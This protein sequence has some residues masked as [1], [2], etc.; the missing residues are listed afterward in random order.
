M[1][2]IGTILITDLVSSMNRDRV[3]FADRILFRARRNNRDCFFH[4]RSIQGK[5]AP[6]C[7]SLLRSSVSDYKKFLSDMEVKRAYIVLGLAEE[8]HSIPKMW[9]ETTI[10]HIIDEL[11]FLGVDPCLVSCRKK[12]NTRPEFTKINSV[13]KQVYINKKIPSWNQTSCISLSDISRQRR[14]DLLK[15]DISCPRQWDTISVDS[16]KKLTYLIANDLDHFINN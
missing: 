16:C 6:D 12:D 1:K 2:R 7:V 3:N 11:L 8:N 13:G 14:V 9:F 5:T 15:C 4:A 10:H